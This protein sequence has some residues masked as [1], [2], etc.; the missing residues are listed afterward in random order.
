MV[1]VEEG[2]GV[3]DVGGATGEEGEVGAEDVVD[4]TAEDAEDGEGGVESSE[5]VVG[6]C[7]I[8]L[9]TASHAGEGVEHAGAAKTD[10]TNKH[11]LHER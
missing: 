5:G 4:A 3:E 11:D 6:G 9:A 8:D 7:G 1:V 2:T 10:E